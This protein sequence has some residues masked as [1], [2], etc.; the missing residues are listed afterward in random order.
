MESA[1][2]AEAASERLNGFELD[3]RPISVEKVSIFLI[4]II[5]RINS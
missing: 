3:G 5:N 2:D 4:L 1:D